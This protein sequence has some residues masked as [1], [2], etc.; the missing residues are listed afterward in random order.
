MKQLRQSGSTRAK[1][2][3]LRSLGDVKGMMSSFLL[4]FG[5]KPRLIQREIPG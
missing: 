1:K 4:A 2:L 5:Y 3:C